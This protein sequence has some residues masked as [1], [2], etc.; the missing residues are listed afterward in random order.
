MFDPRADG[1]RAIRCLI[2]N[3][4]GN[5][6]K[7]VGRIFMLTESAKNHAYI[8]AKIWQFGIG[9]STAY[10]RV[11]TNSEPFAYQALQRTGISGSQFRHVDT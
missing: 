8:S 9:H 3:A 2:S 10:S 5:E 6:S 7:K 4:D 11:L 1:S